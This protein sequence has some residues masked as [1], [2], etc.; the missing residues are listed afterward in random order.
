MTLITKLNSSFSDTTLPLLQKDSALPG[1]GGVMLLDFKNTGTYA[2]QFASF[3][4]GQRFMSLV[5]TNSITQPYAE[6]TTSGTYSSATGALTGTLNL[7]PQTSQSFI[8]D[9][10][11]HDY[12]F[13]WWFKLPSAI[14]N[15]LTVAQSGIS[16][17]RSFLMAS[18][19]LGSG[20]SSVSF[21]HWGQTAVARQTSFS[22]AGNSVFRMGYA[23]KWNGSI[24]QAKSVSNNGS[25]S[26]WTNITGLTDANIGFYNT[27]NS[28][29]FRID[30]GGSSIGGATYRL[31]VEDMTESGRTPEQ[32]W[33]ADWAS[34]SGRFS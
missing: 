24:W 6:S 21:N 22:Y 25:P 28:N 17:N 32:I 4:G 30:F 26:A 16:G 15:N 7:S 14:A 12:C 1:S 3:N 27:S 20:L 34:A 2:T 9:D 18:V 33:A 19:N 11:S 8:I 5:T 10:V 23:W 13:S 29:V 31:L